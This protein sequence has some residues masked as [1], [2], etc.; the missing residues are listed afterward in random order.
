MVDILDPPPPPRQPDE[1]GYETTES[2]RERRREE[3]E[4]L[5]REEEARQEAER[6]NAATIV[7]SYEGGYLVLHFCEA[8]DSVA[9]ILRKIME[10]LPALQQAKMRLI[11]RG[12]EMDPRANLDT[13]GIK[14]GHPSTH[15]GDILQLIVRDENA[16]KEATVEIVSGMVCRRGDRVW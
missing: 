9:S 12:F 14:I 3:E 16:E 4:R 13:Y 15:G 6:I 8:G 1:E 2:E 7:V 5:R 10:K 11:G